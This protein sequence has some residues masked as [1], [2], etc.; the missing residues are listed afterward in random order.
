MLITMLDS[1]VVCMLVR[2]LGV[3]VWNVLRMSDDIIC[4]DVRGRVAPTTPLKLT[5]VVTPHR[6]PCDTGRILATYLLE[7]VGRTSIT[8]EFVTGTVTGLG[9]TNALRPP[10]V[11]RGHVVTASPR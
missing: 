9:V 2:L 4:G 11:M 6:D 3:D 7:L 10:D 1:V 8:Y 5:L